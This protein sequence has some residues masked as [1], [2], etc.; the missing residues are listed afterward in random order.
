M[1]SFFYEIKRGG[2]IWKIIKSVIF[3]YSLI[4]VAMNN[5]ITNNITFKDLILEYLISEIKKENNGL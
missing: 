4:G 5:N 1:N 2:I 3:T